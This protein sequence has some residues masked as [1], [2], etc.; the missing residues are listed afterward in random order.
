MGGGIGIMILKISGTPIKSS[1][2][3]A[4]GSLRLVYLWQYVDYFSTVCYYLGAWGSVVVKV[5]HY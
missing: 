3:W 5:L 4:T 1:V 2:T